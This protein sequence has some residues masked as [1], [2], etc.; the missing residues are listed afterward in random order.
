M[1][2]KKT[3][4]TAA[5]LAMLLTGTAVIPQNGLDSLNAVSVAAEDETSGTEA[6]VTRMY[7]VVL[8][9]NPDSV[10][11]G[12]WVNKLNSHQA[13][14][15]DI[16]LG[17]FFS[18]EYKSRNNSIDQQITDCYHAMLGRDPDAIGMQN[19]RKRLESGMT[20]RTVCAGFAGSS[21]FKDL[22]A[23]YG[24]SAGNIALIYA[25]DRNFERTN[26]VYRLYKNCLGRNPDIAG[27]ENWCKSIENGQTG[28][29]IAEGFIFSSE[30]KKR[31]VSN[32]DFVTML[33]NTILGRNPDSAGMK[34]WADKLNYTNT[35]QNVTNGFLFSSEFKEQCSKA[36]IR[37]GSKLSEKDNTA[38]WQY[39][40]RFLEEIN[41]IRESHGLNPLV[42]RQDL[43]ED[44]AMVRAAELRSN[45]STERPNGDEYTSL[46]TDMV[47]PFE[48]QGYE[49][50]FVAESILR[51]SYVS[52]ALNDL[53]DVDANYMD[54]DLDV[55]YV[56]HY[57]V[58]DYYYG[59][60]VDGLL[61]YFAIESLGLE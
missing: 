53:D 24:I 47:D 17:F 39:N 8:G 26:F 6:F 56:G 43:W 12:N 5:A 29:K 15:S 33:Y 40:V 45:F 54:P 1:K 34:T 14:A 44:V 38:D 55:I 41:K 18:D 61:H 48:A 10:G 28:A 58:R 60:P 25:R 35:R 49:E 36:G 19:W 37:V 3:I 7:S 23:S 50:P 27:I 32:E 46:Y 16:I 2:F 11:L 21:E 51:Y 52:E 13:T 57:S 22:C 4:A 59:S 20:L 9:R 31:Y 30:Y 42:T